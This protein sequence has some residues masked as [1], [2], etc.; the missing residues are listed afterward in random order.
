MTF[1]ASRRPRF[2]TPLK[3]SLLVYLLALVVLGSYLFWPRSEPTP[4]RINS[5]RLAPE[6]DRILLEGVGFGPATQVSL[7]L[8]VNNHRQLRHTVHTW[9]TGSEMVRV[10]RY[11]YAL[12]QKKGLLIL[13]LSEPLR[14]E[15]TGTFVLQEMMRAIAVENDIA[16]I[17][18]DQA[19]LVLVD[20][21]DPS[22][23][24]RLSSL[25]DLVRAQGL[26]VR[27][28][29]LYAA[30]ASAKVPSALAVVDVADP[31]RPRLLGRVPLPG[32]PLG[33][34]LWRDRLLVAAGKAGLVTM[35]LGEGL[36]QVKSRLALPGV[37]HSLLV[38][39]DQAYLA[40]TEAGLVGVD[41]SGE[42]LR[43]PHQ[44][45]FIRHATRLALEAGRLYLAGG[46]GEGQVF[47]LQRSGHPQWL[48][49]FDAPGNGGI[50][51]Y[52][53]TVYLN[54]SRQGVQ[55]LDLTAPT[56]PLSVGSRFGEEVV[57]S[58]HWEKHLLALTTD[59]GHLHL[60]ERRAG[61]GA[62]WL[63]TFRLK[64]PS[65]FSRIHSG[66]VYARIDKEGLEVVD[67]RNPKLPVAAGY[68]PVALRKGS[69]DLATA[70][71]AFALREDLGALVDGAG[72][73][74]LFD[75]AGPNPLQFR[76]GPQLP[77]GTYKLAWG[78]NALYA[79]TSDSNRIFA[80]TSS[81]SELARVYPPF[82][83]PTQTIQSLALM[84]RV[85]VV[86]CGLEGLVTLDVSDPAAPHLLALQ[87]LPIHADFLQLAGTTAHVAD[88]RGVIMQLDLSDPARPRN[89]GLLVDTG[90]LQ[91]F[92]VADTHA[93]LATGDDGLKA[94]PLPQALQTLARD[95]RQMT[96]ALPEIDTSGHYTLRVTD[97]AQSVA[98]PGVLELGGRPLPKAQSAQGGER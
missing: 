43:L 77:A 2:S 58:V 10:G 65:S 90:T 76:P 73:L 75:A 5:A 19:G 51:A 70:G 13:D 64:G 38:V 84:G 40:C 60:L 68:Y 21:R 79:A 66:H 91:G 72:E 46:G 31:A 37:A 50:A 18:C 80:I 45:T 63:A 9:G 17:G 57:Q 3:L 25:P 29:R 24:Q 27:A 48:G 49:R 67:I 71:F 96:L 92:A 28:G 74:L 20:V 15:V 95:D 93:Y 32:Q 89:L 7:A 62:Q 34:T 98:L 69:A 23:P 30:V 53:R 36:P 88:A 14:P 47:D 4:L 97:G 61:G 6:G 12:V 56:D 16:Y 33:V 42:Q 41:L 94:I 81:T 22:S 26:A 35:T 52:G 8:D 44:P 55:V 54:S 39:G 82:I 87:P 11:A 78:E 1:P 59:A 85:M 86:A 83:L